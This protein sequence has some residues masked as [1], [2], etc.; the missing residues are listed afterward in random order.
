MPVKQRYRVGVVGIEPMQSTDYHIGVER[1]RSHSSRSLSRY[2]G[3]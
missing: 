1:Y 2:P 3:G